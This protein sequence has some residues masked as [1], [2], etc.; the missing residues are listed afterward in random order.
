MTRPADLLIYTPRLLDPDSG[1]RHDLQVAVKDGQV[2]AI[3]SE[4]T[5]EAVER[6]ELPAETILLPG[7]IDVHAHPACSG[8]V[9]GI[10]PDQQ[11]LPRGVTTVLSQGDAGSD[12]IDSFV[13]QTIEK[14]QTRV[15]LAINL[16]S[17]GESTP[18]GCL[19]D[20]EWLKPA[21]CLDAIGRHRRYVSALAVNC[22]RAA[23]GQQD[24][25]P[26][27]V[28]AIEVANSSDLPLLYGM[29]PDHEWSFDDQ[30]QQ[31]RPGDMVTYT[32]RRTPHCILTEAGSLHPAI[33]AARQ[34]GI[35]FDVG[36]GCASFDYEV[37]RTSIEGGFQP[38][39]ISS[40]LQRGH[41]ED[42]VPHTLLRVMGKLHA[43]GMPQEAVLRA[44]TSQ[45]ASYLADPDVPGRLEVGAPAD[46]C[47]VR[48]PGDSEP[49]LDSSGRVFEGPVPE[50]LL[51]LCGGEQIELA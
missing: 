26:I 32:F 7:L 27:L 25:A 50:L 35:L 24:P 9:F 10:D 36:H 47:A 38:D 15:R 6:V 34:R 29:R 43:A 23:C 30:L 46:I 41:L 20:P 40:D 3:G 13:E 31:L 33:T 17:V 45:A 5:M 51:V 19:S 28:Q 22:S 37:A 42:P 12:N 18:L 49:L 14:S 44:V 39:T 1:E 21:A 4:L 48:W 11:M 2:V 8:S 16:S